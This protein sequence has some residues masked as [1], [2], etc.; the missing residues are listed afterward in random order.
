MDLDLLFTPSRPET[1]AAFGN[2]QA[3]EA[4]VTRAGARG[5]F[6]TIPG[7]DRTLQW[8]PCLPAGATAEVGDLVTVLM[9]NRGRPWL[10]ASGGGG[11][12]GGDGGGGGVDVGDVKTTARTTPP[13]GW[14]LC[15]GS[16]VSRVTYAELFDVIGTNYGA[17]DGSSTFALPNL[18][19]RVPIG[20]SATR[21]AGTA[22]GAETVA[23]TPAEMPHHAHGGTTQAMDRNIDH[24]HGGITN[25]SDRSLAHGHAMFWG[26]VAAAFDRQWGGGTFAQL[27]TV[28]GGVGWWGGDGMRT[29]DEG[30]VDHLHTFTT[31]GAD[32]SLDHLH[33]ITGEG[34]NGAH[35]NMPPFVALA[36]VIK[37]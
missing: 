27:Q 12:G 16:A 19:D 3:W 37:F 21:P 6:V 31:A 28:G 36:Y 10:L 33:P 11:N 30:S 24:L 15:D 5:V 32:R 20:A 18:Q 9:S 29:N 17:G 22:G 1:P 26:Q 8:G 7:F 34:G 14:L 35:N 23:L 13:P 4:R 25:G 2:S